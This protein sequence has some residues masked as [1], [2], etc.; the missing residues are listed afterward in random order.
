MRLK[1]GVEIQGITNEMTW[2]MMIAND[3]YD[4]YGFDLEIT[5]ALDGRHSR[6]SLH[7]SGNA[8]DYG[9]KDK[10]GNPFT[11]LFMKQLRDNIKVRCGKNFDVV[12]EKN[13]IHHEYQA[14]HR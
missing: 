8:L 14:R 10:G 9:I 2:G 12:V 3:V 1:R 5:S 4:F 11:R 7:Y 13:H 6:N